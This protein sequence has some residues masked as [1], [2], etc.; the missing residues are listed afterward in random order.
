MAV[1]TLP[2]AAMEPADTLV[3]TTLFA[4]TFVE[5][6]FAVVKLEA[7]TV[8]VLRREP[9]YTFA[10]ETV[11]DATIDPAVTFVDIKLV[12]VPLVTRMLPILEVVPEILPIVAVVETKLAVD[13][14]V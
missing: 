8:E 10:A 12:M 11:P 14:F 1:D 7:D 4:L 5:T 2:E 9:T 6:T 3:E 13:T